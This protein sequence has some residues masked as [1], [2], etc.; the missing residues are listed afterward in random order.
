MIGWSQISTITPTQSKK[1][2][3]RRSVRIIPHRA[4]AE[5]R[6][7][8]TWP[9]MLLFKRYWFQQKKEPLLSFHLDEKPVLLRLCKTSVICTH[10]ERPT[11]KFQGTLRLGGRY[12]VTWF[13]NF[14]TFWTKKYNWEYCRRYNDWNNIVERR[15][16]SD[17]KFLMPKLCG[18]TSW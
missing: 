11:S 4:H 5:P 17:F 10:N 7:V 15:L 3:K 2:K 16:L 18:A 8:L 6:V 12:Q 9:N 1:K 14:W 13:T